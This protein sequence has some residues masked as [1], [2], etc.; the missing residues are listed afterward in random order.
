LPGVHHHGGDV[1]GSP[2]LVGGLDQRAARV[3]RVGVV[4][5]DRRQRHVIDEP[6]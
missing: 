6:M 1:V 3:G 4:G 5:E 2:G